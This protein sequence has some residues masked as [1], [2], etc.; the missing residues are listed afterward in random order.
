VAKVLETSDE[1]ELRELARRD[2]SL[3]R[4]ST[5]RG[6]D[7]FDP[8]TGDLKVIAIRQLELAVYAAECQLFDAS[9]APASPV[10]RTCETAVGLFEQLVGRHRLLSLTPEMVEDRLGWHDRVVCFGDHGLF[11]HP[12]LRPARELVQ[13]LCVLAERGASVQVAIDPHSVIPRS[14]ITG[15]GLYDYWFG[16]KLDFARLDDPTATGRTVHG[17]RPELQ[18]RFTF[19]LLRTEFRWSMD[20]PLK[21]LQV[22]ETVPGERSGRG[23]AARF[24]ARGTSSIVICT[25]SVT[26][27]ARASFTWMAL[28]RHS[29]EIA[30]APRSSS[31]ISPRGSLGTASCS[32]SMATSLITSGPVSWVTSSAKTNS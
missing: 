8:E 12:A 9:F 23:T 24:D 32:G 2:Q 5:F 30:T 26:L 18:N 14:E 6:P 25:A 7:P 4:G 1:H 10:D 27:D 20:G 16:M 29:R 21:V 11:P 22:Q 3:Q 28:P 13:D 17:R 31:R 15:A 19:P